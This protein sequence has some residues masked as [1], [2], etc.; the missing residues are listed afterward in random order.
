MSAT[1]TPTAPVT[2]SDTFWQG[3]LAGLIG[4]AT[5]ALAVGVLD[6]VQGRSFFYTAA[7]LG[8][9]LFY[10]LKDPSQLTIWAGPVFAYNGVHLLSFLAL[11]VVASWIVTLSERVPF[12]WYVGVLVVPL[13]LLPLYGGIALITAR[14][15]AIPAWEVWIP[16]ALATIAMVLFLVWEHPRLRHEMEEGVEA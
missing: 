9:T 8:E 15:E 13:A 6:V 11:G 14:L 7:L 2:R 1:L 4:Y 10:G 5:V 3:I 12:L 16:A